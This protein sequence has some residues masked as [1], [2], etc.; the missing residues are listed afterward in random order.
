MDVREF[1]PE[2][3]EVKFSVVQEPW[4]IYRL[5]DGG[6]IRMRPSLVRATYSGR[7]LP[8][9]SAE[10]NLEVQM[11]PHISPAPARGVKQ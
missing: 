2:D 6:E 5:E 7:K 8:D 1:L 11:V 4:A 3:H 10:Y 9:G